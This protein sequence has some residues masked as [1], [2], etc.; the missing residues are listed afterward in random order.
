MVL[1]IFIQILIAH[2]INNVDFGQTLC[3]AASDRGLQCFSMSH[4]KG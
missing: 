1:S 2:Y 4:K 3:F